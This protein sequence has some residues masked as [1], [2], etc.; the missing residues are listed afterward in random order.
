MCLTFI[1][2]R[3]GTAE[4]FNHL[5][6]LLPNLICKGLPRYVVFDAKL[7]FGTSN[8]VVFYV[9]IKHDTCLLQGLHAIFTGEDDTWDA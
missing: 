5:D 2:S 9:S 4:H 8:F 3:F 7:M 6:Y 1:R